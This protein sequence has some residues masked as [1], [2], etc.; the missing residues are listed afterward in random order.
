MNKKFKFELHVDDLPHNKFKYRSIE[1]NKA[2]LILV[3]DIYFSYGQLSRE[4][5]RDN[6]AF[7]ILNQYENNM[8][9]WDDDKSMYVIQLDDH[10]NVLC[11]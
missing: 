1:D 6:F 8:S 4:E 3:P 11:P 9:A 2:Y 5:F 7:D 10:F